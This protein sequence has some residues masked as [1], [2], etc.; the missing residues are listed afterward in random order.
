MERAEKFVRSKESSLLAPSLSLLPQRRLSNP[1]I[2]MPSRQ[3]NFQSAKV[4]FSPMP[5]RR[6]SITHFSRYPIT[7]DKLNADSQLRRNSMSSIPTR[8]QQ[9]IQP[10]GPRNRASSQAALAAHFP[11]V[12]LDKTSLNKYQQS[13]KRAKEESDARI[14]NTLEKS[15]MKQQPR[16]RI[17]LPSLGSPAARPTS[18]RSFCD[19]IS[20]ICSDL[21]STCSSLPQTDHFAKTEIIDKTFGVQQWLERL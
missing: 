11:V 15:A 21:S 8:P 10:P 5:P 14:N 13:N 3:E 1:V 16:R 2:Q 18:G 7:V 12:K 20:G 9:Q 19:S 4:T 17:S 6:H